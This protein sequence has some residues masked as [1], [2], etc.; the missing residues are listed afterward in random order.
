MPV[1]LNYFNPKFEILPGM[2]CKVY[3][4]TRRPSSSL[5]VPISCVVSTPLKTFVCRINNGTIEWVDVKKGQI[6]D[7]MIEVFGNLKE[8]DTLAQ[9]G[10]DE[11]SNG[12]RVKPVL[13]TVPYTDPAK[14]ED[15][16]SEPAVT[17]TGSEP[18]SAGGS[19][20]SESKP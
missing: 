20:A 18:G 14:P 8:G 17:T 10:T 12:T 13:A 6:M 16:H 11:L 3:W 19:P 9:N 2:F 4:P 7:G 15:H 5:F 1:E